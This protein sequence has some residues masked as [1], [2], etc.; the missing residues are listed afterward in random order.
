MSRSLHDLT[1]DF[2]GPRELTPGP[3]LLLRL[4]DQHVLSHFRC[5]TKLQK[6]NKY[7]KI[8]GRHMSVGTREELSPGS[9]LFWVCNNNIDLG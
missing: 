8:F 7:P 4:I 1:V 5:V 6:V 2:R 9:L 3:T